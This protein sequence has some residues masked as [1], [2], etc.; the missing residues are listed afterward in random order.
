MVAS[1]KNVPRFLCQFS[2]V[3]QGKPLLLRRTDMRTLRLICLTPVI[4]VYISSASHGAVGQCYYPDG[5]IPTDYTYIK[6]TGSQNSSCCIP[7]EGDL[8]MS[9]G[10]CYYQGGQYLYRGA[11][12]DKTWNDN[13][14]P[15]FCS[16]STFPSLLVPNIVHS[17]N[18]SRRRHLGR[19][20]LLRRY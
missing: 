4:L 15:K 14:C 6:C 18:N 16:Q 3:C 9:N 17:H 13:S 20:N 5:T 1:A 11:C 10:L 12:S 2:P 8:C 19:A 7:S